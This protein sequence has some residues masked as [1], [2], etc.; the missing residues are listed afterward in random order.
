MQDPHSISKETE[1]IEIDTDEFT[2]SK[3][4]IRD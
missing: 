1:N 3:L 2:Y 4:I